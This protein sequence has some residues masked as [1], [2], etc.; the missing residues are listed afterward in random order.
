MRE[1]FLH[2]EKGISGDHFC[3]SVRMKKGFM[4]CIFIWSLTAACISVFTPREALGYAVLTHEAIID[5]AWDNSILPLLK[6]KFP[7]ATTDQLNDAHAF[8]YG[9]AIMPDMG[10][11]PFRN[12]FFTD[13]VH[14]V[15]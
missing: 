7:G 13:L 3:K 15:R 11:F 1:F 9:G 5:A 10:N 12:L 2:D 4:N 8:S 6:N 14:Y